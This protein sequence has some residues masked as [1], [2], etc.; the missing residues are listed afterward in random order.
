[1]K[2]KAWTKDED[3]ICVCNDLSLAEKAELLDR[4]VHSV[5]A[6]L[7]RI[8]RYGIDAYKKFQAQDQLRY[9]NK[10]DSKSDKSRRYRIW[11]PT[12]DEYIIIHYTDA[13]CDIAAYL[14]RTVGAVR[15]RRYYLRRQD[16]ANSIL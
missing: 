11:E 16:E 1:M 13:D 6:H 10:A 15:M 5:Y 4:S 3:E 2:G 7:N 9:V 14:G 8:H 12:E